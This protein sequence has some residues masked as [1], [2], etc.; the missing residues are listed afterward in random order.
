MTSSEST[1]GSGPVTLPR[2]VVAVA[3]GTGFVGGAIAR[4]LA[5][6]GHRVVV[7]SHRPPAHA[8]KSPAE[9]FERRQ[10]DVARPDELA[11]ALDGV[12]ALVI[13][14]A[15]RNSPIE[16]PRRGRTFERVDAD[17]TV[18]LVDA[19]RAAGVRRLVYISGAGAAPDAPRHW[20][21]AKW[22]AEEAVRS[23]GIPYTI[24][25]P[26]WI[27]GPGDKSLNRF[28][29]FAR[30]LPFVPQIGNGRQVVAP[31]F[32]D[33]MGRLVAD[34]LQTPAAAGATLEV[35]GPETLTMD[36][37][38]REALRAQGRRRLI[39]HVPARLMKLLTRPLTLLPSPP[40]T[41]DAIDFVV[42]SA[43]VD[44]G[45]LHERLPRRLTPLAEGLA[46]Y[47]APKR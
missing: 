34:A 2:L 9:A 27:Y 46:S 3:G 37:V 7:L 16:A 29:G 5:G 15:F 44:S 13:S 45:P 26:S 11:T 41:P 38:I 17:G 42:Q 25:R 14:L 12:D 28:L 1:V 21:R 19:A 32:V 39:L 22:R 36:V 43:Q 18:A 8:G 30:W 33:D 47:L 4:D 20:F 10:A 40:M 6:R 35:G 31:L 24:F 23:S